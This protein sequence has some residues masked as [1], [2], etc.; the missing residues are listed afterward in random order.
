MPQVR[1]AA[2][3]LMLEPVANTSPDDD[4]AVLGIALPGGCTSWTLPV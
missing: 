1:L 2:S 3:S 4:W